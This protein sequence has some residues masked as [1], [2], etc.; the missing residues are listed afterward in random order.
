[1]D[2]RPIDDILAWSR[3]LS[4]WKQDALRRLATADELSSADF[5]ELYAMVKHAV[6]FTNIDDPPTAVCFGED[7]FRSTDPKPLALKSI[8][9]VVNVNR[10]AQN[11]SISF[12]P[13]A[14]TIV[15]G[16]NGSGK[17]GFARILRTACRTRIENATKLRVLADV[18]GTTAG[19]QSAELVVESSEGE[20]RITWTPGG[21]AQPLLM[22]IAVFD[23]MS[24]QLYV[25][26]GSQIRYLPFGLALPHRL[27]S[28]CITLKERL[29]AERT[30]EV[31]SRIT[32]A[33]V[34]FNVERQTAAQIFAKCITKATTD[35]D[36]DAAT[37]FS[38]AHQ[39]RLDQ[40]SAA[41]TAS[42]PS[43]ADVNGLLTW[44]EALKVEL[45]EI[46]VSFSDESLAQYRALFDAMTAARQAASLS[47]SEL[48]SNEPLKGIASDVWRLLWNAARDFSLKHAYIS[49]SFPV[50][51]SGEE[52]A[53]C[54][55]CQQQLSADAASRLRK[56][57]DYVN[58]TLSA[59]ALRSEA[60]VSGAIAEVHSLPMLRSM[61]F[62]NRLKQVDKRRPELA[63]GLSLYRDSAIRRR[64]EV[65]SVLNGVAVDTVPIGSPPT[66]LLNSFAHVLREE[67][68]ALLKS[69]DVEERATLSAEKAELE[70]RKVL[71]AGRSLLISRRNLLALDELYGR[72]LAEVQTKGITQKANEL[73]DTHLTSAVLKRFEHERNSLDIAHLK[74]GLTRKSGQTKAEFDVDSQTKFTK[75]ASDILSEGEQRALALAGFLTEVA[76][77]DGLGPIVIDDPVSSL[78]RNR[79]SMVA[80]RL[81]EEAKVR[82]VVVFT[83]DMVFV[84]E[85]CGAADELGLDPTIVALFSDR[86]AAGKIDPAGLTWKGMDVSKRLG[87]IKNDAA[88]LR[89]LLAASPS[90]YEYYVKNLYGRLRDTYERAVEEVI[91]R[92]IVRR[93]SDVVQTQSLRYVRLTDELAIRFHAGMTLANTHSHDNPAADTVA[94][95]TPDQFDGDIAEFEILIRDLKAEADAAAAARPQMK[96]KV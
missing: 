70:D 34:S 2:F 22:Q 75:V 41:L 26:G 79:S 30:T 54:V 20:K 47:A 33:N 42:G 6:G 60:V 18:Y 69:T 17:S 83:H 44:V 36:I 57:S 72:G 89:K 67:R 3:T 12:S 91:F 80:A 25:D 8:S 10:I 49:Q 76:L 43:L 81:A 23:T 28:V 51:H 93:G 88:G 78:D 40:I 13:T 1:M 31:G 37:T 84:N 24:A 71:A 14:L 61:D 58:N 66:A 19:A 16:R 73:I 77:T 64:E 87:R 7:H 21:S 46:A 48:F 32:L 4:I 39:R 92:N 11:A 45:D 35:A 38:E 5:D 62:P 85:L 53:R 15:Y 74:V 9:G 68:D 86:D 95:R 59:E 96:P 50:L 65:V 56:F 94:V 52:P 55:F 82:Q 90:D 29:D 27:N 63:V